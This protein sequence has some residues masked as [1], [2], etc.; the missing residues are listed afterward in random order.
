VTHVVLL[1]D[2]IFDN[3]AYTNGAPDVITQLRSILPT[4]WRAT[5]LAVDGH[6][7]EDVRNQVARL[8]PDA[9]HLVL[10]VGG[11]DALAHSDLLEQRATSSR[12]LLGMLADAQAGFERRYRAVTE[13]LSRAGFPLAV[14]TIYNGHFL[15][16]E[17]Q[18]LASTALCVFNDVIIR[19]AFERGLSVIDLRLICTDPAD[20]ANP[21]EPSS[22][23]GIK[24]ARAI[25]SA[26][27]GRPDIPKPMVLTR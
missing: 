26:I 25:A 1:G 13:V 23:G 27:I 11:N 18:R 9:S 17:F 8:P 22:A 14:C 2:S 3:G 24:I 21:I 20:Y 7:T 15:D 16:P 10:S 4:N 6:R 19:V 12:R 5:L